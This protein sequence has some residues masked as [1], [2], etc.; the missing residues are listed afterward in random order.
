M[1]ST[2][3]ENFNI[4]ADMFKVVIP[5]GKYRLPKDVKPAKDIVGLHYYFNNDRGLVLKPSGKLFG[6]EGIT[7][8]NKTLI[9]PT[10]YERTNGLEVD[11]DY[12]LNKA[13]VCITHVKYD[14]IVDGYPSDYIGEISDRLKLKSD[15][16]SINNYDKLSYK[17]SIRITPKAT[18]SR[19]VFT[20]YNKG[21]E[22]ERSKNK[23]FR[24]TLDYKTIQDSKHMIR[25]EYQMTDF[26]RMRK[27]FGIP[28]KVKPTISAI[29]YCERNV[30]A[31]FF[32][33]LVD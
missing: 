33:N 11:E 8:Y 24:K 21:K 1:Q 16:Y 14:V 31:D 26:D 3:D 10:I 7:K 17:E 28:Q 25:F 2:K 13:D 20:I 29:L 15:K 19:F 23:A 4:E 22:L 18:S 30:V 9:L 12:F 32:D 6:L 5:Q 27:E